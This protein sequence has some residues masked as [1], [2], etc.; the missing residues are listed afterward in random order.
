MTPYP[1]YPIPGDEEERLRALERTLL[2]DT[3]SD[4]HLD[5]ITHLARTT[6]GMPI[7]LISL[8][9]SQRQWFLSKEGLEVSETPREMAFCAHAINGDEV[10]VIP[11][12]QQD[13]R[14]S[15]NPLVAGD[16]NIRFYAGA[17]LKSLNGQNLGTICLIDRQPHSFSEEQQDVLKAYSELVTREIEIRQIQAHCPVTGLWT[18]GAFLDLSQ[19]EFQRARRTGGQVHLLCFEHSPSAADRL[20]RRASSDDQEIRELADGW[21]GLCGP[22]DLLGRLGDRSFALLLV[23]I[24]LEGAMDVARSICAHSNHIHE[25]QTFSGRGGSETGGIRLGLTA[26]ASGDLSIADM[27]VRAENAHYIATE[28]DDDSI[29]QVLAD[30]G[31][32]LTSKA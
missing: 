23:S 7:A 24:S 5:R 26:Q 29:I 12:A 31:A 28:E 4:Q 19:K 3:P 13:E 18:R 14:F 1:D 20:E 17:P 10:M 27:L 15:T 11:D 9:D 8:V 25:R 2:L 6:L 32:A 22:D 21:S 30:G 16:P